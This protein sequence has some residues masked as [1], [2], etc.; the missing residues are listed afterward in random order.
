MITTL[1]SQIEKH[2]GVKVTVRKCKSGSMRGYVVF[3]PKRK[4]KTDFPTFEHSKL[5]AIRADIGTGVEPYPNFFSV[6]DIAVY[7][8]NDIF[9]Y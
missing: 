1:Q 8:G 2:F 9:N 6:Q 3:T 5:S 7:I 4:S